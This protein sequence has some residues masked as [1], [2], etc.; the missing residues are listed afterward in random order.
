MDNHLFQ[1]DQS[2]RLSRQCAG[3][4]AVND[5]SSA[6]T[7]PGEAA[8][9]GRMLRAAEGGTEYLEW[10]YPGDK[11]LNRHN[12]MGAHPLMS[13]ARKILIRG[14]LTAEYRIEIGPGSTAGV[15]VAVVNLKGQLDGGDGA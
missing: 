13:I 10:A 12:S 1:Y 11:P 3:C 15:K 2:R 14:Y 4:T 5:P 9:A 8:P 7:S 6:G